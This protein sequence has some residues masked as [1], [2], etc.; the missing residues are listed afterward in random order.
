MGRIGSG[1][2]EGVGEVSTAGVEE[3]TQERKF[4]RREDRQA[5]T[6]SLNARRQVWK[7]NGACKTFTFV[8]Y[9]CSWQGECR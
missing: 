8:L 6:T 7:S 1:E 3:A 5:D 9:A 2:G 4:S